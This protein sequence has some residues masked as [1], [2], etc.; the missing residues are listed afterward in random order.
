MR[1]KLPGLPAPRRRR[2][3]RESVLQGA[4]KAVV[5][6][7]PQNRSLVFDLATC[8]FIGKREDALFLGPGGKFT[9]TDCA[10]GQVAAMRQPALSEYKLVLNLDFDLEGESRWA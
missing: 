5:Q 6:T 9:Q 3:F 1:W 10:A 7:A 8:A 4:G 2:L